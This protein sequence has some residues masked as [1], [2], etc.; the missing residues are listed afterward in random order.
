MSDSLNTWLNGEVAQRLNG[1]A[2]SEFFPTFAPLCH[3]A[4]APF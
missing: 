3:Y 2:G 1:K 4:F